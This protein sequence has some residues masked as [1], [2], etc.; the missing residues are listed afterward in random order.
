MLLMSI[1]TSKKMRNTIST[2]AYLIDSSIASKDIEVE[3][4]KE[5]IEEIH[6]IDSSL[7]NGFPSLT[8]VN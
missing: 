3:D 7:P 2:A 4:S 8:S 1:T 5:I 6:I